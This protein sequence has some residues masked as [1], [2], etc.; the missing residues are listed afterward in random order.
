MATEKSN[1]AI[2]AEHMGDVDVV[3]TVHQDGT[4]DFVD[5]HAIGGELDQMPAGYF[6]SIQFIGT[7]SV[8]FAFTQKKA[9]S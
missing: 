3:E 7:V 8:R 1:M 4:I 9:P 2:H 5:T 6:R